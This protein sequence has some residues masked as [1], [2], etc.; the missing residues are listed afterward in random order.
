MK[1]YLALIFLAISNF[2][3]ETAFASELNVYIWAEYLP[4][5]LVEQFTSETGIKV[6][7]STYDNNESLYSKVKLLKD[8][9]NGYDVIVPST[10]FIAKMKNEG[11]I[12]KID[13]SKL[14]NFKNID[15]SLINKPFDPKNEFSVPYLWGSTGICYNDK[16]VK[17][18]VD[19]WESIFNAKYKGKILLMDDVREVFHVALK[20]LGYSGNETDPEHIKQAYE[21]LRD[22]VPNVKIYNS[23][24]PKLNYINEE[25]VIGMNFNGEAY[26]ASLENSNIKY[27]YP[28][29]GAILWMDSLAI[30]TN[31][32]NLDNAYKF[33]DFLLRPDVAKQVSESLGFATANKAALSL[34]SKEIR[35]NPTIYP[36]KEVQE[37]GEFQNDVGEAIVIYEKYWE[38]LKLG[39]P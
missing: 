31:A 26:M 11:L 35:D 20:L 36:S 28:K 4:E 1:K 2:F 25:V 38:M 6:N 14:I 34:L 18:T 16:Y 8:S 12:Q 24:S 3:A 22:L 21:K 29:E 5:D 9:K 19:S 32:Q 30:T 27:I 13:K 39:A 23:T 33:I 17:E 37:K 15:P 10:Y 7:I